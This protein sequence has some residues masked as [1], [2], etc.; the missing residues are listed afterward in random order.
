MMRVN[1]ELSLFDPALASKLQIVS[2]NKIDL[3]EVQ[4]GLSG[5]KEAFSQAGVRV[6]CISAATGQGVHELMAATAGNLKDV[7]DV[8]RVIDEP[9]KIFRPKPRDTGVSVRK[10]GDKFVLTVP[11]WERLIFGDG[12]GASEL[13]GQLKSQLARLGV[14]KAL[15]KAGVKPGDK[16]RCGNLEWEW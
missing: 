7:A 12:L 2:L 16:I 14:N 8:G 10:E 9:K 5:I 11:G 13:R 15:E 6:F 4:A 3:P 1:E